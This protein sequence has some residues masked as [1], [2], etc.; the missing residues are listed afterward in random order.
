MGAVVRHLTRRLEMS[1]IKRVNDNGISACDEVA[2]HLMGQ[3]HFQLFVVLLEML[4]C[5][6]RA[7]NVTDTI[8]QLTSSFGCF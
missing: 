1:P 5:S 7:N 3:T 8:T 2:V 6:L 4:I